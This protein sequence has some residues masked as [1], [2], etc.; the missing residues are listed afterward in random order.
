MP[1][2]SSS[3]AASVTAQSNLTV[4]FEIA[5][6]VILAVSLCTVYTVEKYLTL[7]VSSLT[8][9]LVLAYDPLKSVILP[10]H[11]TTHSYF[12]FSLR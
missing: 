12:G 7:T 3:R 1:L 10:D 5:V 2:N 6:T 9:R 8:L 11:S 4:S